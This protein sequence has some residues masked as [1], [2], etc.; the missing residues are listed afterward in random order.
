M[1]P[2][3]SIVE[4]TDISRL[5]GIARARLVTDAGIVAAG[6]GGRLLLQSGLFVAVARMLGATDYGAF[7]SVTALVSIISTFAGLSCELVLVRNASRDPARMATYLGNG[8]LLLSLSTPLLLGVSIAMIAL[9]SGARLSWSLIAFIAVGDLFF[10]RVNL[11]CAACYQA[12]ERVHR[13]V[14]LNIGFSL[15][16]LAGALI[17]TALLKSVD[18]AHWAYFYTGCA[19]VAALFS[20][21]SVIRDFGF[22]RISLTRGDMWFGLHSSVQAAMY[23]TLRDV[24]KPLMSRL[25]GLHAA[26]LY[27]A[28]FRVADASVVPV[29]ALMYAAYARFF[30]HGRRGAR[31]SAAF[32]LRLLPF[33]IAYGVAAAAAIEIFSIILPWLLGRQYAGSANFL[34]IFAILPSLHA[35]YVIAAD[36]LTSSGHQSSRSAVQSAAAILMVLLCL[37]L[38]PRYGAFGAAAANMFC[39]GVMAAGMWAMLLFH[40]GRECSRMSLA[41]EVKS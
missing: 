17:A 21:A 41:S 19:A 16:R 33:A 34:R 29:R 10:L 25:S 23:F 36:A 38:I 30:R 13:S 15:S 27:A 39:H 5:A 35:A 24:D 31:G 11:L 6:N 7:I 20:L 22:P 2:I 3:A 40:R 1:R 37:T 12:L 18:I 9:V 14:I 4:L 28:A 32:A 8:L 26:G